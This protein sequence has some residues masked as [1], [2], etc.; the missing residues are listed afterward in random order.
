VAMKKMIRR[1]VEEGY[2]GI[3]WATGDIVKER[4]DL[5]RVTDNIEYFKR[6]NGEYNLILYKD[7]EIVRIGESGD[8]QGRLK[9][10]SNSYKDG[11]DEY[12]FAEIQDSS[13]RKLEEK[14]LL[15]EFRDAYGRL[16]KLNP[17][18]A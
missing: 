8:L 2:D 4:Y 13:A 9:D 14:R 10:H 1:A 16:P 12:D 15:E 5:A 11:V 18:T 6:P 7:G 3:A 17:I